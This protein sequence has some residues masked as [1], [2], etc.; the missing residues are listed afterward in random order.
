MSLEGTVM[1][2]PVL[3][4]ILFRFKESIRDELN[5]SHSQGRLRNT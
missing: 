5:T 3:P 1:S 4:S 2:F